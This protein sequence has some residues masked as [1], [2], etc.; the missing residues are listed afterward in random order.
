VQ[1]SLLQ[2]SI[3]AKNTLKLEFKYGNGIYLNFLLSFSSFSR[4]FGKLGRSISAED[5]S[6]P[7]FVEQ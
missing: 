7:S 4:V 3:P 5:L 1:K 2:D 6:H